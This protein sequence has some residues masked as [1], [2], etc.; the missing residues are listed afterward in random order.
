[1]PVGPAPIPP[2]GSAQFA[3]TGSRLIVSGG[4]D[5][6]DGPT[7][8]AALD[9]VSGAWS[10]IAARPE[11]GTCGGDTACTGRWTGRTVL[12]PASGLAYDPAADRWSSI[13]GPR[14]DTPAPGEPAVW[15]NGRL[16]TFGTPA[17]SDDDAGDTVEA[18]TGP[19]KNAAGAYDPAANRWQAVPAGPLSGRSMHTAVWT[20]DALLVWGGVGTDDEL[21]Q[22]DGAAYRP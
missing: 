14:P 22:G 18:D 10:P 6:A 3:W 4:D 1:V 20:G 21:A 15:G 2:R 7:D 19:A 17:G 5:D 8:G 13:A 9:P 16:L 12:F 11:P